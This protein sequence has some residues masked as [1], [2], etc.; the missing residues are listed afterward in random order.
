MY[1]HKASCRETHRYS[2]ESVNPWTQYRIWLLR[3][4]HSTL[5]AAWLK[6]YIYKKKKYTPQQKKNQGEN[7]SY[8]NKIDRYLVN[9]ISLM[10]MK[11]L[12]NYHSLLSWDQ[13]I[14]ALTLHQVGCTQ[15]LN[16][17]Y[18][19][20]IRTIRAFLFLHIYFI[21][22]KHIDKTEQE[23]NMV[24]VRVR[25]SSFEGRHETS[26]IHRFNKVHVKG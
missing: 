13:W 17:G 6:I 14:L 15:V 7:I 5:K 16:L 19:H 21:G 10:S 24:R 22:Y 11:F 25:V 4:P 18:Y 1:V 12:K 26:L 9:K 23:R 2:L 8:S 3:A 20:T